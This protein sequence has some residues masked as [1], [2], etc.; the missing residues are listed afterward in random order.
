MLFEKIN[1]LDHTDGNSIEE[2]KGWFK[3][4]ENFLYLFF[5]QIYIWIWFINQEQI[6]SSTG[7]LKLD[8]LF[9]LNTLV[10]GTI[11]FLKII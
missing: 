7:D 6:L 11:Q 2:P 3:S 4:E 5:L 8:L 9:L 1:K 10:Y